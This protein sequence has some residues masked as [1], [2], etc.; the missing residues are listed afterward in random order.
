MK[1]FTALDGDRI[2]DAIRSGE[3]SVAVVGLGWMGVATAAL[4]LE[5]GARVVGADRDPL[6]VEAVARGK[7]S[8]PEPGTD[9]IFEKA[10]KE[11][12]ITAVGDVSWAASQ[13]DVVALVVPTLTVNGDADY[14]ALINAARDAAAGLREGSCVIVMSTCA[15]TVTERRIKPVL[16]GHSGL[17][18]GVGFALAYSPIRAMAGRA[19]RDMRSYPRIL[20]ADDPLSLGAAEAVLSTVTDGGIV[21]MN[22]LRAAE[23]A[24]IFET[25]YRDL[26]IALANELARLCERIGVDY[27]EVMEAANTQPYSHLH[28]PGVGVGGHCIPVYPYLLMDVARESNVRLP[29]V[30]EARR[31]NEAAPRRAVRLIASVLRESGRTLARS[32]IALLGLSYREDVKE[33]RLSPS[34]EVAKLLVKKG[35]KVTVYDPYFQPG[36]IERLGLNLRAAAT[37]R[38]A[39][40]E[41]HC[42]AIMVAH[43]EFKSLRPSDLAAYM[44]EGKA[45]FDGPGVLDP[46][47]ARSAGLLYRGIGRGGY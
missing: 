36:E 29:L 23:A 43:R 19:L 41:A 31:V 22:S 8:R 7:P 6:A 12:R 3:A 39:L 47:E 44:E 10:F 20:G 40:R 27:Y 17:R 45:V 21:K 4:F 35:V 28:R 18:A 38:S 15:P 11:G 26:N 13:G 34:L 9:P 5:V 33:L 14:S 46:A 37:L 42:A 2:R 24:K 32:R 16:E 25:V 30:E 1:G